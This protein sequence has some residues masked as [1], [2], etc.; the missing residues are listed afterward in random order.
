MQVLP[1]NAPS[2]ADLAAALRPPPSPADRARAADLMQR[3]RTQMVLRQPFFASLVLQRPLIESYAIPTA[4]ADAR[5]R[6]YYNPSWIAGEEVGTVNKA[7]FLL[8]HEVMHVAL[9]HCHESV[10]GDRDPGAANDA[11]DKVINEILIKEKVGEFI[12]GGS[13]HPGAENMMWQDLYIEP[14]KDDGGGGGGGQKPGPGIGRDVIPCPD[15]EPSPAEESMLREEM[16]SEV[17]A[18]AAA[19][20]KQGK[21]PANLARLVEELLTVKT[22]WHTILERFFT[23]FVLSDYSWKRPNRR[24]IGNNLYLPSL[25]REP[26]MGRVGFIGDTS[27]SIGPNEINAF[28]AHFNRIV[29]TCLPE[30][31]V[32]LSVDAKVAGVQRFEPDAFPV[33]WEP[34]GGGGTDMRV[35]WDW[36]ANSGEEYDCIVC[37]TDGYTPWPDSVP[38]PSIVLSTT[39]Q[40]AP[41]AVGETIRFE[42]DA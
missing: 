8:A 20:R 13:R 35:G 3:A 38:F 42:V 40:V 19:A 32:I 34:K 1:S 18:A 9:Q 21:L 4:G 5:G 6:I 37:L 27:G 23:G 39:D 16:K 17:A 10:V 33:R 14:P 30:E 11:Q 7:I 36:F 25:G 22:P 24:F 29:E 26:R 15:G 41:E 12:E 28:N 2:R 31:V